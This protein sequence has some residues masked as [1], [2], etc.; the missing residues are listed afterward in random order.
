LPPIKGPQRRNPWLVRFPDGF[1]WNGDPTDTLGGING[2]LVTKGAPKQA[3]EFL[4]YFVSLEV[5][6]RLAAGNFLIPVYKGASEG[7]ANPLMQTVAQNLARSK[8]HSKLLRS[9]PRPSV[10]RVVNDV[11]RRNRPA[12]A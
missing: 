1:R 8:Y 9:E 6:K 3:V 12:E 2:W 7:L 5:Q 4:K 11:N 10:G